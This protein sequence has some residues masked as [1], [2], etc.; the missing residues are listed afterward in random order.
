MKGRVVAMYAEE[1]RLFHRQD[2][3]TILMGVTGKS[4]EEAAS[5]GAEVRMK[6]ENS[7][8]DFHCGHS[9]FTRDLIN[10]G[11]GKEFHSRSRREG[12]TANLSMEKICL[13]C[14]QYDFLC[15]GKLMTF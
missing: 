4:A 14:T 12:D 9:L 1:N 13:I 2:V 10:H 8:M 7:S 3:S 6:A 5:I 15:E 11:I